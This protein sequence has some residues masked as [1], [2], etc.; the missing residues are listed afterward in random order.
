MNQANKQ[1]FETAYRTG[2]D[3]WSHIPYQKTA[4]Q[5]LPRLPKDSLILDVGSGRGLWVQKLV[6]MGYRLIGIDYIPLIVERANTTIKEEG[7]Q[8]RARFMVGDVCDIPLANESFD[9]VTDIG[10]LQHLSPDDWK[11]YVDEVHRTLKNDGY[12]LNVSLSRETTQFMGL[13]P[14]NAD[15]G[16]FEKFGLHYYFFTEEELDKLFSKKFVKIQ[17]NIRYF[18]TRN[19]PEDGIALVFTL[20]Q[21]K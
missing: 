13:N 18:D 19:D 2:S 12:L 4:L 3:I 20:L 6:R 9:M 16:A 11:T 1:F 21:K 17:Q 8:D 7:I 5:M 14:K 15:T 10:L